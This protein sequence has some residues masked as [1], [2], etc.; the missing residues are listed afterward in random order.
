M[1]IHR[2]PLFPS[3]EEPLFAPKEM[4]I[5]IYKGRHQHLTLLPLSTLCRTCWTRR[6]HGQRQQGWSCQ[7]RKGCVAYSKYIQIKQEGWYLIL[8]DTQ[9]ACWINKPLEKW[10]LGITLRIGLSAGTAQAWLAIACDRQLDY[11]ISFSTIRLR[12]GSTLRS[13]QISDWCSIQSVKAGASS[14]SVR[15]GKPAASQVATLSSSFFSVGA[16]VQVRRSLHGTLPTVW[17][18]DQTWRFRSVSMLSLAEPGVSEEKSNTS[19]GKREKAAE[20]AR[21]LQMLHWPTFAEMV[22]IRTQNP[23]IMDHNSPFNLPTKGVNV[24]WADPKYD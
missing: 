10:Y 16:V 6:C 2:Q 15:T 23:K 9:A 4:E 14:P 11:R 18:W 17:S 7:W 5:S 8:T 3:S 24:G 13:E 21:N 1:K 22:G 19:L 20:G 12:E